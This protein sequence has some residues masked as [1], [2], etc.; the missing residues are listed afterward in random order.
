MQKENFRPELVYLSLGDREEKTK[1]AVMSK[2]GD[3]IRF[4]YEHFQNSGKKTV[5]ECASTR[6]M[7][8]PEPP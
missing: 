5:L 6:K 3:G 4:A 8:I 1:N 7:R 2:V